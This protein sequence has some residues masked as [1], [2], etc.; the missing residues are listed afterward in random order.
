MRFPLSRRPSSFRSWSKGVLNKDGL[1]ETSSTRKLIPIN[2][3]IGR[4]RT[5]LDVLS[6]DISTPNMA[7]EVLDHWNDEYEGVII[8]SEGQLSSA[9]KFASSL[10]ASLFQWRLKGK[11]GCGS[12]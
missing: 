6:P 3:N 5:A 8:N 9:N 4:K 10:R 12:N 11:K 1:P 2:G 7:L